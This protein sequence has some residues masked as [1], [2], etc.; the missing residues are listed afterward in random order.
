MSKNINS[1]VRLDQHVTLNRGNVDRA[2]GTVN[3]VHGTSD[4][5]RANIYAYAVK[6][7]KDDA[8][9]W[10]AENVK[11]SVGQADGS[12]EMRDYSG[13]SLTRFAR[14]AVAYSTGIATPY[15]TPDQ[16]EAWTRLGRAANL[17]PVSAY[18][19]G[20]D[21]T[22]AGL[23][24]AITEALTPTVAETPTVTGEEEGETTTTTDVGPSAPAMTYE[25]AD[26][27][28]TS[29]MD[30]SGQWSIA[31]RE[32][33]INRLHAVADYV[34]DRTAQDVAAFDADVRTA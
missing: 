31:D 34:S 12:V 11:R 23:M 3:G 1:F 20:E 17:K 25:R 5:L 7:H 24:A 29:I 14:L 13:S 19:K 21:L 8:R 16:A 26:D 32:R 9:A 4:A 18:L 6:V 33:L 27:L 15:G 22:T 30:G 28:L 2:V 10:F